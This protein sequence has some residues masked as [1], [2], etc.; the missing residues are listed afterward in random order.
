MT[1]DRLGRLGHLLSQFTTGRK[2]VCRAGIA[3]GTGVHPNFEP[4]PVVRKI[5]NGAKTPR[6][7]RDNLLL[8]TTCCGDRL[9]STT[10]KCG[11]PTVAMPSSLHLLRARITLEALEV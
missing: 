1:R 11:D 7:A 10:A 2:L 5:A 4:L 9:I 6:A 3:R 8:E